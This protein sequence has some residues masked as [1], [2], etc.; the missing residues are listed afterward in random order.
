MNP[1]SS[2]IVSIDR[3]GTPGAIASNEV[4]LVGEP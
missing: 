1:S 4:S 3:A 2:R